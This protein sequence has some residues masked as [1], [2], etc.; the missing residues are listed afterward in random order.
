[1]ETTCCT[2][3]HLLR[4]TAGLPLFLAETK[5]AFA[6][7][8]TAGVTDKHPNR[9]LVV[10]E[11]S[12]GNDG[13]NTVVPYTNDQYY[14]VRPT[15]GIAKNTVLKVNSD[16]GF[17]PS[18]LGFERMFKDGQMAVVHGCSYP[19]PDRSHFV[20][21][22]YWHTGSPNAPEERGWVGRFADIS[23]P[24]PK[25][26][27]IVN[28]AREQ[29]LAVKAQI[30]APVTFY[31][32][33][34][35]VREGSPEAKAIFAETFRKISKS[36]N[37]ALDFVRS[38]AETAAES[39]DFVRTACAEYRSKMDYG[40]GEVGTNLKRIA[41]MIA[42]G[43]PTK[44]YYTNFSG[45]D[46]HASQAT[47]QGLLFNQL[48]DAVLGLLLDL[49]RMGRADDVA[50][51]MFTEFGR[52]VRENASFG[53]DHGVASPMFV[54]ANKL[55]GGFYSQHPSLI[56]LDEGDL[57]MTTDFRS[58]YATMIKEWLGYDDTRAVLKG[59][60]PTLGIFA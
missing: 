28:I 2:R 4:W 48:G 29:S 3:R 13:L 31:D 47:A 14:R 19:N 50:I 16:F 30:H 33:N 51:L 45:F 27:Y 44:I 25:K 8:Q 58:V 22:R 12:G 54:V 1:M 40:Y 53:T 55:K 32:P 39:S 9:I 7:N 21:M 38:I 35:F 37:D 56:D 17:H 20:S 49:K 11:L 34:R 5:L 26:S 18:L 43:S 10:L 6:A 59:N 15:I 36:G 46:T 42:G 52:R 60:Y 24:T 57:K 41:A 23:C